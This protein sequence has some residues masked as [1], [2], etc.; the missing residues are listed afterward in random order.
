[1]GHLKTT[2]KKSRNLGDYDNGGL[3]HRNRKHFTCFTPTHSLEQFSDKR[4]PLRGIS[5]YG[6][7]R[8]EG[9]A[10]ILVTF[11]N[12]YSLCY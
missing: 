1:L 10:E 3:Q 9:P 6:E 8:T 5:S 4:D 2:I 12:I 11:M 7:M